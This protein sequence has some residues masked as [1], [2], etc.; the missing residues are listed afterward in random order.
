MPDALRIFYPNAQCGAMIA[1]VQRSTFEPLRARIVF[2]RDAHTLICTECGAQRQ[3]L[4]QPLSRMVPYRR[5][6]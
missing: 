2:G 1:L 6:Q 5:K 3:W 4:S